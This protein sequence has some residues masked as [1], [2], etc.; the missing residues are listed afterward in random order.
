MLVNKTVCLNK[1]KNTVELI[2]K[3]V[4]SIYWLGLL[5]SKAS[6]YRHAQS[7][8]Y[9]HIG[10]VLFQNKQKYY[11]DPTVHLVFKTCRWSPQ[12]IKRKVHAYGYYCILI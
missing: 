4:F 1:F 10:F 11:I 2:Q 12:S 5:L 8:N 6:I 9:E 7:I 3:T